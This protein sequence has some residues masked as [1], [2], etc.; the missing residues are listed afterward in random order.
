MKK[1]IAENIIGLEDPELIDKI[2]ENHKSDLKWKPLGNME[3]N[4]TVV[5]SQ[6][7]RPIPALME[8]IMNSFDA[9]ALKNYKS[10][11]CKSEPNNI[12]D[13]YDDIVNRSEESVEL[14]ADGV[15]KDEKIVNYKISDTGIGQSRN[16]FE[17]KFLG[18]IEQGKDKRKYSFVQGKF[19]IGS[20][21]V[22]PFLDGNRYKFIASARYNKK[23]KWSWSLVRHN[24]NEQKYEYLKNS[25]CEIPKFEGELDGKNYGSIIKVFDYHQ[26]FSKPSIASTGSRFKKRLERN[27]VNPPMKI[28]LSDK[29]YSHHDRYTKG[30]V[31][32]IKS[33]GL[34]EDTVTITNTFTNNKIGTLNIK[35]YILKSNMEI[36]ENDNLKTSSKREKFLGGVQTRSAILYT[37][38]GQTHAY[39]GKSTLKTKCGFSELADDLI[40]VVETKDIDRTGLSDLFK[41]SRDEIMK[42]NIGNTLK[43]ELKSCLKNDETLQNAENKRELQK[44]NETD[45]KENIKESLKQMVEEDDDISEI[46][47]KGKTNIGKKPD[48]KKKKPDIK[49]KEPPDRFEFIKKYNP[50]EGVFETLDKKDIEIECPAN[51]SKSVKFLLNAPDNYFSNG[52]GIIEI[53]PKDNHKTS[54]IKDGIFSFK[55]DTENCEKGDK[56]VLSISISNSSKDIN[57]KR[58]ID[59]KYTEPINSKSTPTQNGVKLP[60]VEGVKENQ[61]GNHNMDENT[62]I[63][64]NPSD[65]ISDMT[66]FI[67]EDSKHQKRF[68]NENNIQNKSDIV[69]ER[70]QKS[71]TLLSVL[72]MIRIKNE[73]ELEDQPVYRIVEESV[74]GMSSGLIKQIITDK[75]LESW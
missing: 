12:N 19:G 2:I 35:S 49:K 6:N 26:P 13:A 38:N 47:R 63:S 71:V 46:L 15:R 20:K 62:V 59:I 52:D 64:I 73:L 10:K 74:N 31:N 72:S 23:N 33:S 22:Y 21:A 30:L 70:F 1:D 36:K 4:Y 50:Y 75:E 11:N 69:R 18:A 61:W 14:I 8:L 44:I 39:E 3:N 41:S 58:Y 34:Y 27:L 43:T 40:V 37:L 32:Y 56:D 5:H 51:R 48:K 57:M 53:A 16:E 54:K 28:K 25:K 42:R 66:I 45:S 67:N 60:D 9:I 29:R 65:N 55:I 17:K 68:I 7:S 24:S